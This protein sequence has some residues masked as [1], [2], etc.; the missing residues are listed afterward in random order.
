M[1]F[2]QNQ[3]LDSLKYGYYNGI[4]LN[5]VDKKVDKLNGIALSTYSEYDIVGST[6][7]YITV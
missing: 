7:K 6:C 2:S 1:T 3:A 5:L 4:R